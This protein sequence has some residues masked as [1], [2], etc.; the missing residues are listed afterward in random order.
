MKNNQLLAS[1]ALFR[2]LYDSNRDIYDV[3][4][5]FIRASIL[6]NCN[7]SFNV[8]D[9][10]KDLEKTFGFEIPDAV[11][12]TCL[13]NRLKSAG[14]VSS[15]NGEYSVTEKFDRSRT[16]E[17]EFNTA[18]SEYN[19]VT[20]RLI[21]HVKPRVSIP[22]D[23]NEEIKIIAGF[24]DYLLDQGAFGEYVDLISHFLLT[25]QK[26]TE[27]VRKLNQIEEG[28]ILYAG[29]RYSP[30]LSTLGKWSGDLVVY[31]DTE[32][33]FSAVGLNGV[34]FKKIFDDFNNLVKEVNSKKRKVGL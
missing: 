9:C 16:I 18:K 8:N 23:E 6:L 5:E 7:W 11:I 4:G 15:E 10:A 30:D 14:E 13:K 22:I 17:I 32:H 1:A 25:N 26:D 2:E 3:I 28:L 33:L 31:L 12:K 29:I 27:F 24:N 20:Q 21:T 34:L 19:E